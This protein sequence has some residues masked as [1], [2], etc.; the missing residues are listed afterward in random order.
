MIDFKVLVITV[1]LV[2]FVVAL[3]TVAAIVN[4]YYLQRMEASR[5]RFLAALHEQFGRL[6]DPGMRP[7]A[8]R[9]IASGFLGRWSLLAAQ[10]VNEL[11][12]ERRDEITRELEQRS[13]VDR[14]LK[15]TR[16][17]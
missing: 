2:L 11:D 10:E 7:E 12:A 17:R 14:F 1:R 9:W 4:K 6:T 5:S 3:T 13:I 15:D 8:L 16:H